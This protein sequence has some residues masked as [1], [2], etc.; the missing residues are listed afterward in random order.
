MN[1]IKYWVVILFCTIGNCYS[2]NKHADT[3]YVTANAKKV[4]KKGNIVKI[5]LDQIACYEDNGTET[6]NLTNDE[7]YAHFQSNKIVLNTINC[8]NS[9]FLGEVEVIKLDNKKNLLLIRTYQNTDNIRDDSAIL[10]ISVEGKKPKYDFIIKQNNISMANY[11]DAQVTFKIPAQKK[12]L[13]RLLI[14]QTLRTTGLPL[15]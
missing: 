1:K 4:V 10:F 13:H 3:L 12:I 9:T 15:C 5:A 8:D 7:L 2:V 14:I 6:K 11:A